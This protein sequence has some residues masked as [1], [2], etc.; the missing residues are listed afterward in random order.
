[1]LFDT[2]IHYR[3]NDSGISILQ[4]YDDGFSKISAHMNQ[5]KQCE[6]CGLHHHHH[7]H[8]QYLL[9]MD[10]SQSTYIIRRERIIKTVTELTAWLF[11]D[12]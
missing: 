5:N 1:M 7:H 12:Q 2:E 10:I 9:Y 8:C 11:N 4:H 6:G 3:V